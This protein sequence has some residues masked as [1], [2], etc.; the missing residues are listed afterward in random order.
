MDLKPNYNVRQIITADPNDEMSS[1]L[2][3][4]YCIINLAN[5]RDPLQALNNIMNE[6][7]VGTK[8]YSFVYQVNETIV[9]ANRNNYYMIFTRYN[10]YDSLTV[11]I[12][13]FGWFIFENS[14]QS[15]IEAYI[16]N[17]TLGDYN[18]ISSDEWAIVNNNNEKSKIVYE[19]P[20]FP[21]YKRPWARFQ[22]RC[23]G[24]NSPGVLCNKEITLFDLDMRRKAKVLSHVSASANRSKK[25]AWSNMSNMG[26]NA[27]GKQGWATQ[28]VSIT[29]PNIQNLIR[30]NNKLILLPNGFSVNSETADAV[31]LDSMAYPN[32]CIPVTDKIIY[33][34][35][36]LS[37]KNN[38]IDDNPVF[39]YSYKNKND[40]FITSFDHKQS[41][42]PNMKKGIIYD[43]SSNIFATC[44]YDIT[45][46]IY[47]NVIWTTPSGSGYI[48]EKSNC[49]N[50]CNIVKHP[51]SASDVPGRGPELYLDQSVPLTRYII[52]R[53]YG[54]TE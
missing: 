35:L 11:S 15:K 41:S 51:P 19:I 31:N 1:T 14:R 12:D 27:R 53:T 8:I 34:Y 50:P 17:L 46:Q 37:Y 42:N 26:K 3:G 54:G 43:I 22:P 33:S 16:D 25:F 9:Y 28:T 7:N 44:N 52:T 23:V 29:D 21:T 47:S 20:S 40:V 48:L 4:R 2:V 36:P 45:T 38:Y 13:N 5:F 6:H 32:F 30:I 10:L 24:C 49:E 39:Y 18:M